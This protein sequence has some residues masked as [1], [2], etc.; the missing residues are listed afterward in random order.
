MYTISMPIQGWADHMGVFITFEG[1]EGSGK[2]THIA[3]LAEAL[4]DRGYEVMSLREPGGTPVGEALRAIVLDPA[5]GSLSAETELLIYEAARAQIVKEVIGPAL[6]RDAVVICDRFADS[7]IAYQAYGRGLPLDFVERAN[8]FACQGIRPDRTILM[9]VA[10]SAE[11]GLERATH[12]GEA[13]RIELEGGDFHEKVNEG[14]VR[15]AE[16]DA[17]RVRIVVSEELKSHTARRVFAALDDIFPWMADPAVVDD[18]FFAPIDE[19][20]YG[21]K[22][23]PSDALDE[24]D[25]ENAPDERA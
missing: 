5:N 23:A 14:F 16:G 25:G 20:Y 1:G 9:R 2:S 18:A 19:R 11:E 12:H 3:F 24:A 17:G 6:A 21:N 7:T 8:D 10:A 13:D 22:R 4:R 15:I